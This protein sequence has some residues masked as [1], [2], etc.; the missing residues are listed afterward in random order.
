MLAAARISLREMCGRE[1]V[2]IGMV[3][4]GGKI[5]EL[6]S[7][8]SLDSFGRHFLN[9]HSLAYVF[10]PAAQDSPAL[11]VCVCVCVCVFVCV[12][13]CV[14]VCVCVCVFVCVSIC[15]FVCVCV[16]IY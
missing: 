9:Q 8:Y 14:F 10:S 2:V 11:C 6:S 1:H 16:C 15:V 5:R 3:Y 13:I 4:M 12:S 7:Y